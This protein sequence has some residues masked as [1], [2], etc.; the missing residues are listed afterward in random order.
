MYTDLVQ[1][2]VMIVGAL[3]VFVASMRAVEGGFSGMSRILM[4]HDRESM[5][6][7]GTI[8]M[9]GCLSWYFVFSLGAA[10]QPHVIT[11]MMMNKDVRAARRML[12]ISVFGYAL[13][14]LLWIGIGLA[15]RALVV[16]GEFAPLLD[17]N[18]DPKPDLAAPQFLLNFA[19]PLLAGI[20]PSDADSAVWEPAHLDG[21]PSLPLELSYIS[22]WI[23]GPALKE[24]Y[25]PITMN[26]VMMKRWQP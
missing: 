14:A 4:E 7:W 15:M 19:H 25:M 18:G 12:P 9:L 17:A 26:G 24:A 13:T 8:G 6:P 2:L 5:G 16:S 1:G 22:R 20:V 21:L 3:L 10:G 23:N 11:K